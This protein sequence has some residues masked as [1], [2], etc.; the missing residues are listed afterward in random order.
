[1]TP[2]PVEVSP[3]H[4]V[5]AF[6][7]FCRLS[8][9]RQ[10]PP[11]TPLPVE[12]TMNQET[13]SSNNPPDWLDALV[14]EYCNRYGHQVLAAIMEQIAVDFSSFRPRNALEIFI[15][16]VVMKFGAGCIHDSYSRWLETQAGVTWREVDVVQEEQRG[17]TAAGKRHTAPA[18]LCS[19]SNTDQ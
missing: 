18:T 4:V 15:Y 10:E 19:N 16:D 5:S 12:S 11:A 2:D 7:Q 9:A 6:D 1:M 3:K 8:L 17:G 14:S 13:G